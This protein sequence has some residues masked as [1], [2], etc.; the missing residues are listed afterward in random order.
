MSQTFTPLFL[1]PN[2]AAHPKQTCREIADYY[3]LAE[4]REMLWKM[5]SI[6]FNSHDANS[7]T[8]EDRGNYLFFYQQMITLLEAA[9]V[10]KDKKN[11]KWLSK[12]PFLFPPRE[13]M[14]NW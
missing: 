1:Q 2:Q 10:M 3:T 5:L 8:A 9:H 14:D 13:L 6:F 4:S 7:L 12:L 11:A